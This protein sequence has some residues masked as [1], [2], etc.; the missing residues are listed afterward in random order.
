MISIINRGPC[1]DGLHKYDVM[2]TSFRHDRRNG[3]SKCLETAAK[4][5]LMQQG[6]DAWKFL[7]DSREA[8]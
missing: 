3:L 8:T 4:A 6:M 2:I 1:K 5:V 7:V